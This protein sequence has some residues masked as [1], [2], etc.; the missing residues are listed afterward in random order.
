MEEALAL[1]DA[2]EV[3]GGNCLFVVLELLTQPNISVQGRM[4]VECLFLLGLASS[5]ESRDVRVVGPCNPGTAVRTTS[6]GRVVLEVWGLLDPPSIP[7]FM[8][9]F[10]VT[11][12]VLSGNFCNLC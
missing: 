6:G 12:F 11:G 9:R 5:V 7:K 1:Q 8:L 4:G 10:L 3:F 2:G